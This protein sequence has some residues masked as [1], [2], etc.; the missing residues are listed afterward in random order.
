MLTI[1]GIRIKAKSGETGEI[2]GVTYSGITLNSI[3][4]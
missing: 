3:N 1:P 2:R 4:K